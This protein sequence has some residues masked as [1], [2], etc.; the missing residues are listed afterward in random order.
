MKWRI[1]TTK[2]GLGAALALL[3]AWTAPGAVVTPP[4]STTPYTRKFLTNTTAVGAINSLG[5]SQTNAYGFG[6]DQFS[7]TGSNV[8]IKSGAGL[9][10][11][12]ITNAFVTGGTMSNAAIKATQVQFSMNSQVLSN[13]VGLGSTLFTNIPKLTNLTDV[14][15]LDP[16]AADV[17]TWDATG[18]R[19]TNK[20]PTGGTGGGSLTNEWATNIAHTVYVA[21]NGNDL[22]AGTMMFP[23]R[24][25]GAAISNA[26]DGSRVLLQPGAYPLYGSYHQNPGAQGMAN[27]NIIARNNLVIDG[28]NVA[29]ITGTN[30]L[31][32]IKVHQCS[33]ILFTGFSI[34]ND[35][36][37]ASNAPNWRAASNL[38]VNVGIFG[39]ISVS[40]S[41]SI[42]LRR[43]N[44]F[45]SYDHGLLV[46]PAGTA[47][48]ETTNNCSVV[49]CTA[50]KMGLWNANGWWD[51]AGFVI[52]A[53]W[54]AQNCRVVD[55][56][57]AVE[58]YPYSSAKDL[59]AALVIGCEA[60]NPRGA[61]FQVDRCA[62]VFQGNSVWVGDTTGWV[63]SDRVS[64]FVVRGANRSVIIGNIVENCKLGIELV[65]GNTNVVIIG[66]T[67][68]RGLDGLHF[69]GWTDSALVYDNVFL[70]QT[71]GG[72]VFGASS[73]F[74]V[75]INSDFVGNKFRQSPVPAAAWDSTI[76]ANF[77]GLTNDTFAMN[78]SLNS[79][80]NA[81]AFKFETFGGIEAYGSKIRMIDNNLPF[82]TAEHNFPAGTLVD[83]RGFGG[84][85]L[86][87]APV[88]VVVS[89]GITL[90]GDRK[91]VWPGVGSGGDQYSG[92]SMTLSNL[93]AAGFA[94]V[95]NGS[96]LY[97][98][99][100]ATGNGVKGRLDKPYSLSNALASVSYGETVLIAPG[101]YYNNHSTI[102]TPAGSEAGTHTLYPADTITIKGIGYPEL[103]YP[104]GATLI[105]LRSA[106]NVTIE[107]LTFRSVK[108]DANY[109]TI[110]N[111]CQ[112]A[113]VPFGAI[114]LCH[115]TN[116]TI[117]DC[118][119][120]D[121]WGWGILATWG[122]AWSST[123]GIL[124][125]KCLF[126]NCGMSTTSFP[127]RGG[128]AIWADGGWKIRDN[129]M[130]RCL[131]GVRFLGAT[132][133]PAP[134]ASAERNVI[135]EPN[136]YGIW[137]PGLTFSGASFFENEITRSTNNFT[138]F[139]SPYMIPAQFPLLI[140][141]APVDNTRIEFN[142]LM[143]GYRAFSHVTDSG[144]RIATNLV[145]AFNHCENQRNCVLT[146][147]QNIDATPSWAVTNVHTEILNNEFVNAGHYGILWSGVPYDAR[148][149]GNVFSGWD[150]MWNSQYALG[151]KLCPYYEN[152]EVKDNVFDGRLNVVGD[153]KNAAFAVNLG[154]NLNNM[155]LGHN[156][157]YNV[158][159]CYQTNIY[160]SGVTYSNVLLT[161]IACQLP[162]NA[163]TDNLTVLL[164]G[165][166]PG[167]TFYRHLAGT[168]WVNSRIGAGGGATK[169][170]ITN[171][172]T[173]FLETNATTTLRG[174]LS[175][176]DWNTFNGKQPT[177]ATLTTLSA[178]A[179]GA[180]VL[181]NNGSGTLSWV[182][183]G[184][185][186]SGTP[187]GGN[188]MLQFN[189]GGAFAGLT[190][191]TMSNAAGTIWLPNLV[192]WTNLTVV[193][194]NS[195]T[196]LEATTLAL[197]S[198]TPGV[199]YFSTTNTNFTCL[200]T[201]AV[202]TIL[203]STNGAGGNLAWVG[204]PTGGGGGL[205][206]N[207]NQFAPDPLLSIKSA[208][209]L[210]NGWFY[211]SNNIGPGLIVYKTPGLGTNLFEW[212]NSNGYPEVVIGSNL[213]LR[214]SNLIV[215]GS[216]H[217][218]NLN[219]W[220]T[221]AGT[222]YTTTDANGWW[223]TNTGGGDAGFVNI[224]SG[225][226]G[227]GT[228]NA[229]ASLHAA[230]DNSVANVIQIGTTNRPSLL[231]MTTNGLVT[232]D[233]LVVRTN[234]SISVVNTPVINVTNEVN[235]ATN[236]VGYQVVTNTQ[237]FIGSIYSGS[238][239]QAV[240]GPVTN[241]W[242][243]T[244]G[245]WK[246]MTNDTG[247]KTNMVFQLT[248]LVAGV[249]QYSVIYGNRSANPSNEF[250]TVSFLW[251]GGKISWLGPAPT[252]GNYDFN[253]RSN[254]AVM[255]SMFCD[256]STNVF[257]SY[258]TNNVTVP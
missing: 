184:G 83:Y 85:S 137:M 243:F 105:N 14:G 185:G 18:A 191:S 141:P 33:N 111:A 180:G 113:G 231:T 53:G 133:D 47:T 238:T 32:G 199:T 187:G 35:K 77:A 195:V 70:A 245:S 86:T 57:V 52:G 239:N 146:F 95:T 94:V 92:D 17:L 89:G 219:S 55:A 196:T 142:R 24:S 6:T 64:G 44:L 154:T 31:S 1:R 255:V 49:D 123:N 72:F 209:Q 114:N 46:D 192:V 38:V 12:V 176:T 71:R 216:A 164:D 115:V 244:L 211:P 48:F 167:S 13:L 198:A 29:T 101:K 158:T 120:I 126:E 79:P 58:V 242:D 232:M 172:V 116:V 62:T 168:N 163:P 150:T 251:T 93:T 88:E 181:T 78:S 22:W 157:F 140:F 128:G 229:Q 107:G 61:G 175:S 96:I 41:D 74:T 253:V 240:P 45:G 106:Q 221:V 159:N 183:V 236:N 130:R 98:T 249:N 2:C 75:V 145:F 127:D 205:T 40:D 233:N 147:E 151:F 54:R 67:V 9:T 188:Y 241:Q 152:V 119:F 129:F 34:V 39:L 51:G 30:I 171:S 258:A 234:L 254:R 200:A 256:R 56:C 162:T 190:N 23:Y 11:A 122:A 178:L 179:D 174:L 136:Y 3:S 27:V 8:V 225:R 118:R 69:E 66:N 182:A 19:W 60:V 90:G 100:N 108:N 16:A 26:P 37:S 125:E 214:V 91:T 59:P 36:A 144:R 87:N 156:T 117:R 148:I 194:T 246:Q 223:N 228:N 112:T 226:I 43:I 220:G 230:S 252:N 134:I 25:I 155:R 21:T 42:H 97:V 5:I 143:G 218:T 109:V 84:A 250:F 124:V 68:N 177:D 131:N 173:K 65:S 212:R 110:S 210:T 186:G 138:A 237:R 169:E 103:Y 213:V 227:I 50:E 149:I 139:V 193:G 4:V 7:V 10:N 207:A 170:D 102:F 153:P 202:G 248:N 121:L 197:S 215:S 80:A 235:A 206:T 166:A 217:A 20:P 81:Y 201:G 15:Y 257:A 222:N 224:R 160:M 99:T 189:L 247:L 208:A 76:Y 63:Q 161:A 73:G 132:A 104:T 28:Q 204:M 165:N 135:E 203:M 82:G